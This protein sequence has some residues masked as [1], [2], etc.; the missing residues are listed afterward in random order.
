MS[1]LCH[2][3]VCRVFRG[4]FLLWKGEKD[5][6]TDYPIVPPPGYQSFL[7]HVAQQ[8]PCRLDNLFAPRTRASSS[9]VFCNKTTIAVQQNNIRFLLVFLSA[10]FTAYHTI[11]RTTSKVQTCYLHRSSSIFIL[12]PT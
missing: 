12:A 8:M 3:V 2:D 5:P 7:C 4:F 6:I 11:L 1:N 10:C 9:D